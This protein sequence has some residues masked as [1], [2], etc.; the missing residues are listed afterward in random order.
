MPDRCLAFMVRSPDWG[1]GNSDTLRAAGEVAS[2]PLGRGCKK[3]GSPHVPVPL[4][5]SPCIGIGRGKPTF[6]YN[7]LDLERFTWRG[8][9]PSA[10]THTES[11]DFKYN[12]SGLGKGGT[13][14][15]TVDGTEVA[16]KTLE[17]TIPIF[18]TVD[19]TFDMGT[20]PRTSVDPLP[21]QVPFR[22]TGTLDSVTVK[23]G[24]PQMSE[25]DKKTVAL[26][27]AN[28]SNL[29]ARFSPVRGGRFTADRR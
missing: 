15:L 9:S 23:I 11:F 22:F 2:A 25:D 3:S 14:L 26:A 8:S 29:I 10:G 17:H 1:F 21:Y 16:R 13:G 20:D 7:L 4:A 27:R 6:V 19:E 5:P 18:I 24:P 12:G 28:A